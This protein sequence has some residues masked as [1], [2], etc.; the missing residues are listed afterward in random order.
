MEIAKEQ[1][2]YEIKIFFNISNVFIVS[3]TLKTTF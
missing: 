1:H 2:L 3:I